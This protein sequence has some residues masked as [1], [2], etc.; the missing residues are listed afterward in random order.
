MREI[1]RFFGRNRKR[2][3][4]IA[5]ER[6]PRYFDDMSFAETL[7]DQLYGILE[8]VM[9]SM[10]KNTQHY[11]T[12]LLRDYDAMKRIL[13]NGVEENSMFYVIAVRE[14]GTDHIEFIETYIKSEDVDLSSRYSDIFWFF[15]MIDV[16]QYTG[17]PVR[18]IDVYRLQYKE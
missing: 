12:D 1:M 11:H 6:H 7:Q 15:A 17:E 16:D 10:T 9:E 8:P 5:H 4:R 13:N 18:Y 14:S 3:R 2:I